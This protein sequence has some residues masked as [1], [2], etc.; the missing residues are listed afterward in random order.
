[1]TQKFSPALNHIPPR[2]EKDS[3]VT[4][5]APGWLLEMVRQGKK[6]RDD[7]AR[8]ATDE[9]I[10]SRRLHTVCESARCPNRG[11]CFSRGTATFMI[12]GNIC[13]RNCSFCAVEKGRPAAA[14]GREP[15]RL[16]RAAAAMGLSHVVV[17]SVTR[18]DLPD[19]GA[20]HFAA[21]IRG[22]RQLEHPPAV[23]VLTP[24]F[25]GSARALKIVIDAWPEVFGHN[26]ETVPR[27]YPAVRPGARYDR[28]L[29]LL[30]AAKL[31]DASVITKSGIMLGLGEKEEEIRQVLK[32]LREAG[33]TMVTIGQYLAPSLRHYPVNRYVPE[34]EFK[35]WEAEALDMGFQGVASAPLVRSSYHAGDYYRSVIKLG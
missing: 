18:D 4:P 15:R 21:V 25:N 33:V 6:G 30:A 1:M 23:E 22:L 31:M 35:Q 16:A 34:E 12:L 19:G 2:R 32:D 28:S 27:L 17:T 11:N 9:Q 10:K 8:A 14:D 7:L 5:Q 3:A 24:D 26:V 20:S 29:D 13:T